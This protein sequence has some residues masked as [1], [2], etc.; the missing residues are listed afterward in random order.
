MANA[1]GVGKCGEISWDCSGCSWYTAASRF[2]PASCSRDTTANTSSCPWHSTARGYEPPG[3]PWH[4]TASR[5][6]VISTAWSSRS[7]GRFAKRDWTGFAWRRWPFRA[8]GSDRS[9]WFHTWIL[10]SAWRCRWI[11]WLATTAR[12]D[13][14]CWVGGHST[15]HARANSA[16]AGLAAAAGCVSPLLS[17]DGRRAA[18]TAGA[19][20]A[21]YDPANAASTCCTAGADINNGAKN[22]G[23]Q[24]QGA[25]ST[26]YARQLLLW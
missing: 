10:W 11:A 14:A 12:A 13:T 1:S 5:L 20:T 26:I 21:G 18:A 22:E 23:C 9:A 8:A 15:A 24:W 4:T 2:E 16:A 7:A 3:S 25:L 19:G 6:R 17:A